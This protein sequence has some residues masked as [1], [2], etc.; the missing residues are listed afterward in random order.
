MHLTAAEV[1]ERISV[2]QPDAFAEQNGMVRVSQSVNE[3]KL[4]N[5]C[6]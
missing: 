2:E 1:L 4:Q 6:G 3:P 5:V